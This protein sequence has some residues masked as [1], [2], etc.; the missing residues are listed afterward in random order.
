MYCPGIYPMG[1]RKT[2]TKIKKGLLAYGPR[3]ELMTF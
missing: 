3:F 1:L 2:I